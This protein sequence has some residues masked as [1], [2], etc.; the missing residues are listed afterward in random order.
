M[1]R[2]RT[3]EDVKAARIKMGMTQAQLAAA[4]R[5]PDP[6][7]AGVQTIGRWEKGTKGLKA[8]PGPTQ[9]AIEALLT[10]WRP[11]GFKS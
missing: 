11:C 2:V 1:K 9:V 5:I 7:E 4:L 6:E 10:G 3:F 8:V